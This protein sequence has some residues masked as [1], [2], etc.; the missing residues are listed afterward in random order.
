MVNIYDIN[1]CIEGQC[2]PYFGFKEVAFDQKTKL[3]IGSI[4]TELTANLREEVIQNH[5]LRCFT[6]GKLVRRDIPPPK[7]QEVKLVKE[8]RRKLDGLDSLRKT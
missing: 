8:L 6:H 2:K 4:A 7:K 1:N 3:E 5:V